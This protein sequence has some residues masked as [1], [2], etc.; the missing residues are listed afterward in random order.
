MWGW[1]EPAYPSGAENSSLDSLRANKQG[2][3]PAAGLL[4]LYGAEPGESNYAEAGAEEPNSGGLL[5]EQQ[6][7][8][9]EIAV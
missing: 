4:S 1:N 6:V 8:I 5:I 7:N 3:C 2:D 9:A